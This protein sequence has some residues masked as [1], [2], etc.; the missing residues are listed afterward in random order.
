MSSFWSPKPVHPRNEAEA[1]LAASLSTLQTFLRAEQQRID[2]LFKRLRQVETGEITT[3]DL[4]GAVILSPDSATRNLIQPT[5]QL[6]PG[7][8]IRAHASQSVNPFAY[9]NSA[10]TDIAYLDSAGDLYLT[11]GNSSYV[12][13][14]ISNSSTGS[15]RLYL[16]SSAGDCV[17]ALTAG[18]YLWTMGLDITNGNY[19]ISRASPLG[20]NNALSIDASRN[21]TLPGGSLTLQSGNIIASGRVRF[22]DASQSP[23]DNAE[24]VAS[25][26]LEI[27]L[28]KSHSSTAPIYIKGRRSR[29]TLSSKSNPQ[30]GDDIIAILAQ[31]RSY[32]GGSEFFDAG[33]IVCTIEG[34]TAGQRPGTQWRFATNTDGGSPAT[35]M[36]IKANGDIVIPGDVYL[37]GSPSKFYE[38]G[39]FT[40]TITG[41]TTSPTVTAYYVRV[42]K[43]VTL[44]IPNVTGTSNSNS[45]TI[46]GLPAGMY[47]T[48][49][50]SGLP[51][52]VIDQSAGYYGSCDV[53]TSGV[54]D[55]YISSNT[56]GV[57]TTLNTPSNSFTSSGS[58][59]INFASLHYSLQ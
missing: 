44:S 13:H 50:I 25:G 8:V 54:I 36:T 39:S 56:S 19:V 40:A 35:R 21:V 58:K 29:G 38:E 32:N 52:E 17:I 48:R 14:Y 33:Y 18:P 55:V 24:I 49:M 9:Q 51:C 3:S 59:G 28:E 37:G 4:S 11:R 47:P 46:T 41:C 12:T 20:N 30:D 7:M 42:G 53:N 15:S 57:G 2:W 23:S 31:P 26:G 16:I 22:G 1:A 43:A 34:M 6:Y 10:G 5:N 27:L 45:M